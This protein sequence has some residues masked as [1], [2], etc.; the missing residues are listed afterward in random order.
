MT[1]AR[2]SRR[3]VSRCFNCSLFIALTSCVLGTP[4]GP[5]C[6]RERHLVIVDAGIVPRVRRGENGAD[7]EPPGKGL[8]S[9]EFLVGLDR[10]QQQWVAV[11]RES[12]PGG[13]LVPGVLAEPLDPI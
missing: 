13:V 3:R 7:V 5:T 12:D 10:R 2:S 11:D 4:I 8:T 1:R 9:D 6:D